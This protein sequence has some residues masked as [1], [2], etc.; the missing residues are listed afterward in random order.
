MIL[1]LTQWLLYIQGQKVPESK[2]KVKPFINSV[3]V[4][5]DLRLYSYTLQKFYS[6]RNDQGGTLDFFG[7]GNA[8]EMIFL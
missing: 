1:K 6:W 4:F 5:L 8:D 7:W 3:L 2:F